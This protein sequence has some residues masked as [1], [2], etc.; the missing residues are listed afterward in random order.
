M[1]CTDNEYYRKQVVECTETP[2]APDEP[3]Y[4]Y[5]TNSEIQKLKSIK[6]NLKKN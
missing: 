2:H 6:T 1:N 3:H 5:N 4:N